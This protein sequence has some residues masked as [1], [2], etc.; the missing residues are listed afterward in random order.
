MEIILIAIMAGA[1]YKATKG[2]SGKDSA[3]YFFTGIVAGLLLAWLYYPIFVYFG[4]GTAVM[5]LIWR[6]I[7]AARS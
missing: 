5:F 1:F 2:S 3:T 6:I 4:F 7:F